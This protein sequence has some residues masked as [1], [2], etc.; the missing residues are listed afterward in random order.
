[1][2]SFTVVDVFHDLGLQPVPAQTWSAG[3]VA[4]DAYLKATGQLPEKELRTKTGGGGSHCFAVYPE[5]WRPRVIAIVRLVATEGARQGR[6][7]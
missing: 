5:H 6:L 3:N 4:R 1:M 2:G 7:F